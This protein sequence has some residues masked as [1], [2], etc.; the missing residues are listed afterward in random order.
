MYEISFPKLSE[1]Y[2]K[3]TSW[4]PVE[5]IADL[6]EHDHVFCM[7]YKELYFRHLYA[8]TM[9]DLRQRCQ[10]WDNYCDL[11]GVILHGSVNM[12]LP[13]NWLWDMV[14]EFLYQFQSFCQYRGKVS[15]KSYE[16]IELLKQCGH[17]S[18]SS[19]S[20]SSSGRCGASAP[21]AGAAGQR[22]RA[23]CWV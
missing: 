1:R 2:F 18:G 5:Y 3:T 23:L 21:P 22:Q 6:V 9:P 13:N 16:E 11:F 20:S 12:V 8:K 15:Q 19:S 7:L 10:S 14:D 4:P 17:V